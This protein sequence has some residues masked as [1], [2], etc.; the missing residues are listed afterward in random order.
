[1]KQYPLIEELGL[2]IKK[3][4]CM[5]SGRIF[6]VIEPQDLEKLLSE[7]VK[8]Y[9]TKQ[10]SKDTDYIAQSWEYSYSETPATH[11]ALLIN[12]KPTAK[13]K[14]VSKKELCD[15]LKHYKI[16]DAPEIQDILKRIESQGIE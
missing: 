3:A 9:C 4:Q 15:L 14:P 1:M 8:V 11:T 12:I 10:A 2:N 6:D 5:A 7:G 16:S 13:A